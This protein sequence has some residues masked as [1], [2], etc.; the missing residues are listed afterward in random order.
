MS[1]RDAA[2][3]R[4][5]RARELVSTARV[6]ARE[7]TDPLVRFHDRFGV[8]V[9][10]ESCEG[11]VA[12]ACVGCSIVLFAAGR[13]DAAADQA[14]GVGLACRRALDA[15]RS[16]SGDLLSA[17]L[18]HLAAVSEQAP[19][20]ERADESFRDRMADKVSSLLSSWIFMVLTAQS[21]MT[22]KDIEYPSELSASLGF[23]MA[24]SFGWWWLEPGKAPEPIRAVRPG[25][26]G[27]RSAGRRVAAG[28]TRLIGR[29][30]AGWR[31]SRR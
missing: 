20:L 29:T 10:G 16:G 19:V 7:R 24:E 2:A 23:D 1:Q 12:A 17:Y 31:R 25:E 4:E 28:L 30:I 5:Q 8:P 26:R 9:D 15:W 3:H 27:A 14:E 13:K 6:F 22:L 11:V 21:R 18:A